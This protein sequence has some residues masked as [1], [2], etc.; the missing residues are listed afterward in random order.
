M[1]GVSTQTSLPK[2]S[3][4]TCHMHVREKE[5]NQVTRSETKRNQETNGN[6]TTRSPSSYLRDCLCSSST[7]HVVVTHFWASD[8]IRASTLHNDNK[9]DRVAPPTH[10]SK[11]AMIPIFIGAA[12]V[13]LLGTVSVMLAPKIPVY[14]FAVLYPPIIWFGDSW[15]E[16]KTTLHAKLH[17]QNK[18]LIQ[19]DVHAAMFDLYFPTWNGDF[20]QLGHVEDRHHPNTPKEG[21]W[22]I[23][24]NEVF[25]TTDSV[26]LRIKLSNIYQ[27]FSHLLYQ[28][29]RGRGM[30]HIMSTGMTHISTPKGNMKFTLTF[31]CD[32][33]LNAITN[34]MV[35]SHCAVDQLSPGRWANLTKVTETM[36]TYAATLHPD[37]INGTVLVKGKPQKKIPKIE[38]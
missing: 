11:Y 3:F 33:N 9:G 23:K 7:W 13:A 19:S 36:H 34:R 1:G 4:A 15:D 31:V 24:P 37:P 10:S 14:E 22:K 29:I 27:I 2:K 8:L 28:L 16:L 17:I 5:S 21:F 26:I 6:K 30:L 35:G 38:V 25:E 32:T 18:N 20:V 12:M